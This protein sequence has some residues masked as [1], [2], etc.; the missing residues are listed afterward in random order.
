MEN[1][2]KEKQEA[3][4]NVKKTA[5]DAATAVVDAKIEEM[6]ADVNKSVQEMQAKFKEVKQTTNVVE[7]KLS[8]DDSLRDAIGENGEV[9]KSL[10]G[11]K[12]IVLKAVTNA[13][14]DGSSLANQT[15]Q[16]R[17][18]LY[19]SPYSPLYLRNIFPIVTTEQASI[20]I[21]Q[22]Q[23][24]TGAAAIWARGT[25]DAG[26][27]V[28]KPDVSPTYKEV[29]VAMKW[30]AGITHVN[31]ELLMNVSYL[32]SSVTNTLLYSS[33]GI[34]AAENAMI[35]AYL[36]A[37]APAYTGDKTVPVEK[38][39]DAAFNQLLGKYMNPTHI[40]MNQADY[41]TYVKFNKA[42]GSG[43]YDLPNDT[44]RGFTGTG[45]ETNVAIVPVPALAAGT[46]YVIS[47]PEF[48]FISRMTPELKV[49]EDSG[50]NF[51]FNKVSFRIE[52]MVAFIAKDLNAMV[53]VTL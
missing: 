19:S 6:K 10:S 53:K 2:E 16:V 9:F 28:A 43:E 35:A 21:P 38:L 22:I 29:S 34:F 7:K 4:E 52:E 23:A 37:N 13:S 33:K 50:T 14:F 17:P 26:A 27:D 51:E 20:I 32:Q 5:T 1:L 47:A 41:L 46:A 48:E 36:L 42:G 49:S 11:S 31:R 30:I 8:L 15:T 25:G 18:N 39:I 40:L 24:I 45:L 44:L 3:L 12:N